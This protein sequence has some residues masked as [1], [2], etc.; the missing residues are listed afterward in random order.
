MTQP[1]PRFNEEMR[2]GRG[3]SSG[4]K[5]TRCPLHVHVRNLKQFTKTFENVLSTPLSCPQT[6]F[7]I[8]VQHFS[9]VSVN[10]SYFFD[11]CS[12]NV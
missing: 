5:S 7:L 8:I 3:L 1:L 11:I 9:G 4:S 6:A 2:V 12:D 10:V